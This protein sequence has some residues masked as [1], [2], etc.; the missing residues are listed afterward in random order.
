MSEDKTYKIKKKEHYYNG[1]QIINEVSSSI[2]LN[3]NFI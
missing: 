2:R 3:S 1:D